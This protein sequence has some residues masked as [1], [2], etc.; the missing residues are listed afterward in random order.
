MIGDKI[1]EDYVY[2]DN[3]LFQKRID[4]NNNIGNNRDWNSG[5]EIYN[6]NNNNNN[7]NLSISISNKKLR[8]NFYFS[9]HCSLLI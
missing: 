2:S 4:Y 1:I 7:N 6:N 3:N 5:N 8:S 9:L